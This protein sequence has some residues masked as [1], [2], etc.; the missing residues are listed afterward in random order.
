MLPLLF[1]MPII[2]LIIL[3]YAANLEIKNI[4]LFLIDKDQSTVS[5]NLISKF[6]ASDYFNIINTSFDYKEGEKEML[7]GKIDI[8]IEIPQNFERIITGQKSPVNLKIDAVNGTKGTVGNTYASRIITEFNSEIIS[9]STGKTF[10]APIVIGYSYWFNPDMN[11]STFMSVGILVV[12]PN[13]DRKFCCSHTD[14]ERKR[15][16]NYRTTQCDSNKKIST[17]NREVIDIFYNRFGRINY[18]FISCQISI[19]D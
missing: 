14:C 19:P 12:L 8:A 6:E 9:N 5:R 15:N 10:T 2:Q 4:N 11:Y 16:R 1:A 17:S 18:R 13:Y 3:G 7:D